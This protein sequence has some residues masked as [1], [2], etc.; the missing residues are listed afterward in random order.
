M[1]KLVATCKNTADSGEQEDIEEEATALGSAETV[2]K[3]TGEVATSGSNARTVR[4]PTGETPGAQ[5][6]WNVTGTVM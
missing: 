2:R 6:V 5:S 3:L 4:Q 1:T